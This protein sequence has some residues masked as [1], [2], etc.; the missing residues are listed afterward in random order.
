MPSFFK[1]NVLSLLCIA[2]ATLSSCTKDDG[3]LTDVP[4]TYE[5]SRNGAS[6]VDYSGQTERLDMLAQLVN[7]LKSANTVGSPS[8]DVNLLQDSFYFII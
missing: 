5:F 2:L 1:T 4:A 8:L 7:Y 3:N 6:T